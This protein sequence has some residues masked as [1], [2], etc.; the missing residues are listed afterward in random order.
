MNANAVTWR[1]MASFSDD[2]LPNT[3]HNVGLYKFKMKPLLEN[4]SSGTGFLGK[5]RNKTLVA[6][7]R[8]ETKTFYDSQEN[9]KDAEIEIFKS[10][11]SMNIIFL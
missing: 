1:R 9:P 2:V 10:M 8:F 4:G 5:Y 7:K 11:R 3:K 6:I